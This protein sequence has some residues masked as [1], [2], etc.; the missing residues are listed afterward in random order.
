[1]PLETHQ[2]LNLR[3]LAFILASARRRA[4]ALSCAALHCLPDITM[5]RKIANKVGRKMATKSAA[6]MVSLLQPG[7]TFPALCRLE[8]QRTRFGIRAFPPARLASWAVW[9][10]PCQN[11]GTAHSLPDAYR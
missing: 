6:P 4:R 10:R 11:Y 8:A 3:S 1:M 2:M 7:Y 5:G 9:S